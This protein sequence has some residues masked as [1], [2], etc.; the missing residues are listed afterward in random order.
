MHDLDVLVVGYGSPRVTE[1]ILR[2]APRLRMVGDTHGDRFA[3]RVD[4]AACEARG[5][6]VVDTTNGSSDP[7]AEWA[8]ALTLVGLRNAGSFFRRLSPAR[9]SGRT[10]TSC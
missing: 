4:V 3:A 6:A 1:S 7:V 8:L 2:S 9:C 5:I 10:A